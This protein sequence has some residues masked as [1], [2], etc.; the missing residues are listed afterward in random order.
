MVCAMLREN[1]HELLKSVIAH[2]A[3]RHFEVLMLGFAQAAHKPG[4]RNVPG[5]V[6]EYSIDQAASEHHRV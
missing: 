4:D 2:L 1:V 3:R 5:A 6:S